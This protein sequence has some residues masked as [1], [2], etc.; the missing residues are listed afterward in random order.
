MN[1]KECRLLMK[2]EEIVIKAKTVNEAIQE[3]CEQTNVPKED[4]I[5]EIIEQPKKG[6][7]GLKNTPAIVKGI[8]E[9]GKEQ[10]AKELL[11]DL[12]K[13]MSDAPFLLYTEES[14]DGISI[15][16]QGENLGFIIGRKGEVLDSIQYL[17]SLMV[18]SG[19]HSK[20]AR[21]TV[22]C[23]D[24]RAERQKYLIDL[25]KKMIDRSIKTKKSVTM[26]PM[27]SYDRRVVHTVIQDYSDVS[28]HSVG[29]E[30]RRCVVIRPE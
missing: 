25:T 28:S 10:Q 9:V 13:N 23:N 11:T 20:Y 8:Y 3:I 15:K 18:N 19:E 27:P 6:F 22:D 16:I 17:L 30:P 7:L 2:K 4:I 1:V 5:F 12:L 29:I 14:T 21:I 24:Y 26:E